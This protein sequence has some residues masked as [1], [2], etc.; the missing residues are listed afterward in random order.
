MTLLFI[1]IFFWR[2]YIRL[3]SKEL[4]FSPS[5]W[6][7]VFSTRFASMFFDYVYEIH[8]HFIQKNILKIGPTISFTHLK[9]ILLQYFQFLGFSKI[10]CIQRTYKVKVNEGTKSE[11]AEKY[12]I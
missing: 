1:F 4:P 9:I 12:L 6:I 7:C 5:V 8:N 3:P 11:G 2:I 10:R